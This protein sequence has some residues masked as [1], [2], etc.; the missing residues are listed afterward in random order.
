MFILLQYAFS[1]SLPFERY[2][3]PRMLR[4]PHARE[5]Q[6]LKISKIRGVGGIKFNLGPPFDIFFRRNFLAV[7]G[8]VNFC[9]FFPW[10][11]LW[12]FSRRN[13]P[14]AT[15]P[16][17]SSGHPC[18]L[19]YFLVLQFIKFLLISYKTRTFLNSDSNVKLTLGFK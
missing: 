7:G 10:S 4:L 8:G 6:T 18:L 5:G 16:K 17:P 15:P 9:R 11:P 12:Y 13:F 1:L 14:G 2:L 19:F 3:L